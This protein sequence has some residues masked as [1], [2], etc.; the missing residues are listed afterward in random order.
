MEAQTGADVLRRFSRGDHQQ[1]LGRR[2]LD[3]ERPHHADTII[4]SGQQDHAFFPWPVSPR[5][6]PHQGR[7][8]PCRRAHG[9]H[10][11]RRQHQARD[12]RRHHDQQTRP[13]RWRQGARQQQRHERGGE[14]EIAHL[15]GCVVEQ[16]A[17]YEQSQRRCHGRQPEQ[18]PRARRADPGPAPD[19][20]GR[21]GQQ[22]QAQ[23]S[24]QRQGK[25]ALGIQG[26]SA[27]YGP[28]PLAGEAEQ[29]RQE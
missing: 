7:R 1:V 16:H 9:L 6:V 15:N 5:R 29:G 27:Q 18:G 11:L 21:E 24:G 25:P 13:A 8:R 3:G 17:Q 23:A 28:G 26:Q 2:R 14:G 20:P 22:D 10:G 12:R 19:D 4:A